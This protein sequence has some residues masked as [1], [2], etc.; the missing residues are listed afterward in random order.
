MNIDLKEL[1]VARLKMLVDIW[2]K[3]PYLKDIPTEKKAYVA[4]LLDRKTIEMNNSPDAHDTEA[5][6]NKIIQSF[7]GS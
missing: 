5:E 1:E 2:D 3:T 4:G 6:Y 7:L